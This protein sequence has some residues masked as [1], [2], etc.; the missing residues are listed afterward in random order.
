[1][2]ASALSQA[3]VASFELWAVAGGPVKRPHGLVSGQIAHWKLQFRPC[4][5]HDE[6]EA[7]AFLGYAQRM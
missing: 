7:A 1:M 2:I 3:A 6:S 5:L 4:K